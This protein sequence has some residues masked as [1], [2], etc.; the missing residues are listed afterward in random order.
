MTQIDLRE[1]TIK[2]WD[3]TLPT[4]IFESQADNA[5][6]TFTAKSRHLGSKKISVTIVDPGV[7]GPLAVAVTDLD[8]VVT[9]EY[10]SGATRAPTTGAPTTGAPTTGAPTTGAPTTGAPTTGAP[11][12]AAPST[13]APTVVSTAIEIVAAIVANAD[14]SALITA[15]AAGTGAGVVDAMA[16]DYLEGANSVT[17]KIGDGNLSYT[18]HSK[19]DFTL[20]R[21]VMNTVRNGEDTPMDVTLDLLWDWLSSESGATTPTIEETLK[22]LGPADDWVSSADDQCQPYCVDIELVN[23]PNCVG[24][25]DEVIMLEEYYYESLDHDLKKGSVSTKGRC[26]RKKATKTRIALE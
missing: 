22:Q 10:G 20:D 18:E 14:A 19:V 25:T 23:A 26:N 15:V 9:L 8:I 21:G 1:A 12:T 24:V 11:T 13:A 7:D 4:L 3:G 16:K 2:I 6:L 5:D 17:V